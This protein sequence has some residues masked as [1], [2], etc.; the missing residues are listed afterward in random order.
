MAS[1][2]VITSC[3]SEKESSS[4][5]EK[6]PGFDLSSLDSTSKACDDFDS[7]ANGGWKKKIR[8]PAQKVAGAHLNFG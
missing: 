8:F 3:N 1:V 2:V 7:Y 6:V 5:A 4:S